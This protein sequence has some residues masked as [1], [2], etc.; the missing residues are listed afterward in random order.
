MKENTVICSFEVDRD[1]YDAFKC[2]VY[3]NGESVKTNLIRY[4][5]AVVDYDN[6]NKNLE[7]VSS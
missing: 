7:K 2:I 3:R 1:L 4:M 6:S 5:Q